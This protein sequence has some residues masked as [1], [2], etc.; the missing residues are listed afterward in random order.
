MSVARPLRAQPQ[1]RGL[2]SAEAARRL[3]TAGPN[4]IVEAEGPS[5]LRQ[6]LVNFVQLFAL[7]LWAGA[8]LALVAGMPQLTAAIVAVIDDEYLDNV[9]A[10]V[11]KATRKVSKAI[12]KG[13]YD[14]VVKALDEGGEKIVKAV[15]EG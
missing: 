1:A 12:D 8:L 11:A 3:A 2:S 9:D 4:A 14:D 5:H 15:D 10:A 6:F 13:D 7:L